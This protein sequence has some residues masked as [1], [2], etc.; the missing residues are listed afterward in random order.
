MKK[1]LIVTAAAMLLIVLCA[2][3]GEE[4]P[5]NSSQMSE[6]SY[7]WTITENSNNN[8][9]SGQESNADTEKQNKTENELSVNSISIEESSETPFDRERRKETADLRK[10]CVEV[11]NGV[12]SGKIKNG[13]PCEDGNTVDW[14][15]DG[16]IGLSSRKYAARKVTVDDV[17]SYY[18]T[19]YI[20][21][22]VYIV[23]SSLNWSEGKLVYSPGGKKPDYIKE[24]KPLDGKVTLGE[25][26]A[27]AG[28]DN[29]SGNRSDAEGQKAAENVFRMCQ[30]VFTGLV[31]GKITDETKA[32]DGSVISWPEVSGQGDFE[33]L[34]GASKVTVAQVMEY[35]G[36]EKLYDNLYY[37]N[38]G[39]HS[40]A[41]IIYS[42]N[43][44]DSEGNKLKK[45]TP[46]TPL[47][48]LFVLK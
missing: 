10:K 35:N 47:E 3:K 15:F 12:Y 24:W 2:C 36:I 28:Y 1:I 25:I 9:N 37:K 27:E 30:D 40:S 26:I 46:D 23:I 44:T 29:N 41:E 8:E 38:P 21:K 20:Y 34:E 14:A 42:E 4:T 11:Y 31:S 39:E 13:Y 22:D 7:G 45:L 19:N 43:G 33:R 18:G 32:P 16:G 6:L 17:Q 5:E 48:E